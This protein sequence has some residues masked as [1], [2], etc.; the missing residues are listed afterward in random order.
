MKWEAAESWL[1][2]YEDKLP[3]SLAPLLILGFSISKFC[4]MTCEVDIN[5]RIISTA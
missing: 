1:E 3:P 4:W 2:G 5:H